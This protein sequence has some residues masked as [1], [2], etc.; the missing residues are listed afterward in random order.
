MIR[1]DMSEFME[2]HTTSKLIG[3]PPGYIGYEEQGGLTEKI[4]RKPYSLILFDEIEKAHPDVLNILLQIL[5]DG[6]LTDSHSRTVDFRNTVI[7]MTSNIG[8]RLLT[9]KKT[10]GFKNQNYE[11]EN[12]EINKNVM[13]ELKKE[14][15]PELINRIDEIIVFN[16]LEKKDLKQIVELMIKETL[17]RLE[18][19]HIKLKIEDKVKDL[20][21]D[22][23]TDYIYGARPLRRAVQNILEDKIAEEILEGN[24]QEGDKAT[25]F[26]ENEKIIIK[27]GREKL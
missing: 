24:L 10:L 7:I 22:K 19:K 18:Q 4:R 5:E 26:L 2:A 14:L 17:E 25:L 21:V 27:T 11:E 3:S 15:K 23:G 12:K 1:I 6:I 9:E 13:H 8:A 20:I 16:K